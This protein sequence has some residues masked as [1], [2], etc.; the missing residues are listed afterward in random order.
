MCTVVKKIEIMQ[1]SSKLRL[2]KK[3]EVTYAPKDKC[4]MLAVIYIIYKYT[5]DIHI[6]HV[7][8]FK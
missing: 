2:E 5:L 3:S 6:L 7:I 4:H 8:I 1:F